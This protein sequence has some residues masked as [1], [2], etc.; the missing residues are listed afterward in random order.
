MNECLCVSGSIFCWGRRNFAF[1]RPSNVILTHAKDFC[2]KHGPRSSPYFEK[3][4][5][6]LPDF[7]YKFPT[8]DFFCSSKTYH[9]ATKNTRRRGDV[10]AP[11]SLFLGKIHQIRHISRQKISQLAIFRHCSLAC[12]HNIKAFPRSLNSFH[13]V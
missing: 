1:F 3:L 6:K 13:D 10:T 8:A 4:K 9:L 2:D 7:Y 12:P 11:Q 5:L